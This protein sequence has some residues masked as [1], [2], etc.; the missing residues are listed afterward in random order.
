MGAGAAIVRGEFSVGGRRLLV[1]ASVRAG[2]R[3]HVQVNRQ[4]LR[5][6]SELREQLPTLAFQPDDLMVVKGPPAARREAIDDAIVTL[7]PHA[8]EEGRRLVNCRRQRNALLIAMRSVSPS[9]LDADDRR[10][11]DVWDDRLAAA[12]DEWA[13]LRRGLIAEVQPRMERF[14][15]RL[16]G[17]EAT[18]VE[19]AYEPP[20]LGGGLRAALAEARVEDLRSGVTTVGPHRDDIDWR[21]GGLVARTH[22]SQGNQ[23][24]LALALRLAVHE[25]LADA[26]D[27]PPLLLLDDVFSELDDARAER[28]VE[29]LPPAQILLAT[30][31]AVPAAA[32]GGLVLHISDLVTGSQDSQ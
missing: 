9:R 22:A 15:A 11:L 21:L 26:A 5:R 29:L 16:T 1:E 8:A 12:G 14:F 23:R 31:G 32:R 30:A 25:A 28:L 13:Q 20:W 6:V 24:A 3:A 27:E 18:T 10:Q 19:M 2:G 4:P 17:D 7:Q